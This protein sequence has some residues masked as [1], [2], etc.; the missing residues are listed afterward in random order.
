[1]PVT[2]IQR[3]D[4]S[5][6]A[7]T[8]GGRIL[9][10]ITGIMRR[11]GLMYEMEANDFID[12]TK[13]E[14]LHEAIHFDVEGDLAEESVDPSE[15]GF[16]EGARKARR[17]LGLEV[18]AAEYGVGNEAL[19]YATKIDLYCKWNGRL[20]V[21]NWKTSAKVWRFWPIQSALEALLFTPEPVERL[22]IQLQ[23]DGQFRPHHYKDRNDFVVA[24]A[25]LTC[26]AWQKGTVS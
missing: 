12:A 16:I 25:A 15:W 18:I 3:P 8:L 11:A 1:M 24:R 10:G 20:T 9:P 21:V 14:R 17:D 2:V 26:A 13:G 22:G 19:G 5:Y 7:P 4:H 23:A 6:E